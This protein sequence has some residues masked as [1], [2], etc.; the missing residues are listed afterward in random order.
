[1]QEHRAVEKSVMCLLCPSSFSPT[2]TLCV[3]SNFFADLLEVSTLSA[4]GGI[5][6]KYTHLLLEAFT[7]PEDLEHLLYGLC[8]KREVETCNN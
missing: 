3:T 8:G 5:T 4:E 2:T 7:L 1:M 6:S